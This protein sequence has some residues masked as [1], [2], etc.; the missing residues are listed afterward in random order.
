MRKSIT[1]TN[2]SSIFVHAR[3]RASSYWEQ[4]IER[5]YYIPSVKVQTFKFVKLKIRSILPENQNLLTIAKQ[6]GVGIC[7][8]W[9]Q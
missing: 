5:K 4:N 2:C 1:T 6:N 9:S 7:N 3:T 8:L